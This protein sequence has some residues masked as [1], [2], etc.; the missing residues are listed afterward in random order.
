MAFGQLTCRPNGSGTDWHTAG[1]WDC[2]IVPRTSGWPYDNVILDQNMTIT[3]DITISG[4]C[5]PNISGLVVENGATLTVTGALLNITGTNNGG[6]LTIETG[7]KVTSNNQ[8]NIDNGR[9]N[10]I[11]SGGILEAVTVR[12]FDEANLDNDGTITV[13]TFTADGGSSVLDNSGTITASGTMT[14]DGSTNYTNSGTV[15]A[16]AFAMAGTTTSS[17]SG[18]MNV[19]T[20]FSVAS[21]SFTGNGDIVSDSVALTGNSIFT[22]TGDIDVVTGFN[23]ANSAN[24]T[25]GVGGTLEALN[26]YNTGSVGLSVLGEARANGNVS[27]TGSSN[28]DGDGLLY[29]GTYS[30]TGASGVT[31]A[32]GGPIN[33][34]TIPTGNGIDLNTCGVALFVDVLYFSGQYVDGEAILE[35]STVIEENNDY[36]RILESENL[37]RFEEIG[38]IASYYTNSNELLT[39]NFNATASHRKG[40]YY[41]LQAVDL[42]GIVTSHQTIYVSFTG[43]SEAFIF[44]NPTIDGSFVIRSSGNF[45][46]TKLQI[47]NQIGQEIAYVKLDDGG[48]VYRY[49]AE[50]D[51]GVYT[52]NLIEPEG[53]QT[54]KLVVQ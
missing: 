34:P 8:I 44:P 14:I 38:Q 15:N 24:V 17:N 25:I 50:L 53:I 54:L 39:Y 37:V 18:T 52:I 28:I 27:N 2:G 22:S 19:T 13:T 40:V 5:A 7:G 30:C 16:H 11:Q 47:V 23:V 49:T 35:W 33:C 45:F 3:S 41:Q 1:N 9:T 43:D 6:V 46:N 12:L 32:S 10:T 29:W 48:D 4:C 31:C 51:N 21:G 26:I 20:T 36:F 42:D